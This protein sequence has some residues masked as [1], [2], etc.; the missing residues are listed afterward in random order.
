MV[1]A[2]EE[3][4]TGSKKPC[5][6]ISPTSNIGQPTKCSNSSEHEIETLGAELGKPERKGWAVSGAVGVPHTAM[7]KLEKPVAADGKPS[8]LR[9]RLVHR[10]REGYTIGRFRLWVT[11][12]Q[13]PLDVG[14]PARVAE[15]AQSPAYDRTPEETAVLLNYVRNNDTELLKRR[16]SLALA[17]QPVPVEC[18][19]LDGHQEHRRR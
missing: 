2:D 12:S 10:F 16:Q 19:D 15:A 3:S 5:D 18:L 11:T 9:F 1:L 14:L 13:D 4:T 17:K 8:V 7:F 6:D